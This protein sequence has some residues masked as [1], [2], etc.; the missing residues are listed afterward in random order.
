MN[1]VQIIQ[2][3]DAQCLAQLAEEKSR[4]WTVWLVSRVNDP[5]VPISLFVTITNSDRLNHPR[6]FSL[7]PLVSH[8]DSSPC[9]TQ[10]VGLNNQQE[11]YD[12]FEVGKNVVGYLR[13]QIVSRRGSETRK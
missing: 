10:L 13:C 7:W 1:L 2:D 5:I 11:N 6:R 8:T 9:T 3:D 12:D 4:M